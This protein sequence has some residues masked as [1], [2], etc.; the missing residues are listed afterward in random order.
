MSSSND[1]YFGTSYSKSRRSSPDSQGGFFQT[2]QGG[3]TVL[4]PISSAFPTSRFPVPSYSN[5]YNTP[6][7]SPARYEVNQQVLYQYASPE[8]ASSY[9]IYETHDRYPASFNYTSRTPPIPAVQPDNRKLPPLA[10]NANAGWT[11]TYMPNYQTGGAGA[12]IRSPTASYPNAYTYP[13]QGGAYT[14]MPTPEHNHHVHL[15]SINP[16]THM[17][18]YEGTDSSR[19]DHHRSS[20]PYS[21]SSSHVSPPAYTPPPVSPT[22]PDESTIKKKRKRADARQLKVLN[23][24]YNRTAFPSTEERLALAKELDMSARSVQIWFQNKRQSMR[25]TNRQSS[26]VGSSS[27]PFAMAGQDLLEDLE[28]VPM[29]YPGSIAIAEAQYQSRHS[30]DTSRSH[31]SQSSSHRRIR[32]NEESVEHRDR[33]KWF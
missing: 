29:G 1:R 5:P 31:T 17:T 2:G 33:G 13:T 32:H 22:S 30:P 11:T 16:P 26:T 7:S 15:S 18:S 12:G 3:R 25:Q 27:Q 19:S 24:T 10:T 8:P 28:P 6:R 20:S 9:P 21:R 23:E 4:P 14:Y